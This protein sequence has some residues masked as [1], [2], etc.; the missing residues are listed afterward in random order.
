MRK[1]LYLLLLLS[2]F[3]A[4]FM[5]LA[6]KENPTK[7][8]CNKHWVQ[9]KDK[10]GT[11]YSLLRPQEYLSAKSIAR[12][13][14]Q[15][16]RVDETDLPVNP[17]YVRALGATQARVLYTSKWLNG[18]IVVA[19]GDTLR[20]IQALPFVT[21]TEGIGYEKPAKPSDNKSKN[22]PRTD[23]YKRGKTVY[24]ES[25]NQVQMLNGIALHKAGHTGRRM[26]CAIFDGGF[27]YV[28]DMPAFD[29]LFAQN[30]ILQTFDIAKGDDYVYESSTHGTNVLSCMAANLP[31]LVMG[32][33]YGASFYLF[34]TEDVG[35]ESLAEEFN[36]LV[37]A[38][39]AD[40]LGVD[41]VN[42]SLGYTEFDDTLTSHHYADL[43]GDKAVIT[44]AADYAAAKGMLMVNS[45]GNSGSDKWH[46]LGAPADADSIL[47]VGATDRNGRPTYFSS[48][49]PTPDGRIKPDVSARGLASVVAATQGYETSTAS[50]TSFSSPITAGMVSALWDA[51]PEKSNMDIIQTLREVSNK[52][53][54]PED[55]LGY[56]IP[57]YAQAYRKLSDGEA[58]LLDNRPDNNIIP[59][60]VDDQLE[61]F[62]TLSEDREVTFEVVDIMGNVIQSEKQSAVRDIPAVFK[63]DLKNKP[64]GCYIV[65]VRSGDWTRHVM[66][67]KY[68]H[69]QPAQP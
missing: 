42:S 9:F 8:P 2:L 38:E 56:G 65:Y 58:F 50:G 55:Q 17:D 64:E 16:L 36:W 27:Q 24:G 15:G 60:P 7:K 20:K 31:G 10:F 32:T 69:L 59:N 34:K 18:A 52:Y 23:D 63:A 30:R 11:P 37:A 48:Y 14:A 3:G 57:D 12:R 33:G 62:T 45:A 19:E 13:E 61:L 41:V 67:Q 25:L 28:N 53:N 54:A 40:S 43:N 29:S 44:R 47:T 26:T 21:R 5:L 68:T 39:R 66:V 4:P 46:Y 51:F 1:N 49:G 6:Q 35:S 22:T